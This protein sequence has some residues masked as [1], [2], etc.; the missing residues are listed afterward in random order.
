MQTDLSKLTAAADEWEAMAGKFKKL[1]DQYRK[2]IHGVTVDGSWV[3]LSATAAN[4]HFKVTLRE[5]QA[6]QTEAKAIAALVRDAYSQFVDLRGKVQAA[7]ADAIEAGM[8]VS[9]QGAVFFDTEKLSPSNRSAY[10]HDP[11]YQESGRA[12]AAKWEQAID[13]AVKAVTDADAGVKI[14][15]NAVVVDTDVLDGTMNGFNAKAKSDIEKYEADQMAEIS[16]R[17]NSGTAT[18]QD[19]KEAERSLRDN[20]GNKVY[21][22]TLL[23]SLGPD[24]TIKFTNKLNDLAYFDD[25]DRKKNYLTLQKGLSTSLAVA[26]R[27]PDFGADGK[28]LPPGSKQET[29]AIGSRPY[30]EAVKNWRTTGDAKFYNNWLNGMKE[31]GT[32]EYDTKAV[33]ELTE[34][35]RSDDKAHGYQSLVTMMQQGGDYSGTFLHDLAD[36]IR[37]A[38]DPKQKGNP[39]IWDIGAEYD[40]RNKKNGGGWFANDPMDGVLGLMSKD[41]DTATAYFDPKG[42]QFSDNSGSGDGAVV[43]HGSDRLNYLQNERDWE[44]VGDIVLTHKDQVSLS[45]PDA[46]DADSGIGFG[47]ALEAAATGRPPG[48]ADVPEGYERHSAAQ[49]RVFEEI[50]RSY[51][52]SATSERHGSVIPENMRQNMGNIVA[53][54]PD[55]IHQ[56]LGKN[57]DFSSPEYSTKPNDLNVSN[58]E[59][60]RF[61]REASADGGAYRTIHDSQVGVIAQEIDGLSKG[62]L[63]IRPGAEQ[64][65]TAMGVMRES[66]YV[67]GTLDQIRAD[68]LTDNRDAEISQNNWNK[69]YQY[70]LF[71]APVTGLPF[72]GDGIQR[73][74][75]IGTGKE[76]E[77]LNNAATGR[78]R[79]E[80][81]KYYDENGYPRL[82]R[83]LSRHISE[84]GI[85]PEQV[86]EK[87]SRVSELTGTARGAYGDGLDSADGSTGEQG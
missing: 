36:D 40:G 52:E 47:L 26:T 27:V 53:H 17:I 50:I 31:V 10:Q 46:Q 74:I 76:A 75:D 22:Q 30:A 3:G 63:T 6:A 12:E 45:V 41:P 65:D 14:A 39:D 87:G 69:A 71:G 56:I 66:G 54:Y 78:A 79:E 4:E 82:N 51:A 7:R 34:L 67:M 37:R 25:K 84:V 70:H 15:L 29:L 38:E 11:S 85:P 64:A 32:K 43:Q 18:A 8:K 62:D 61:L 9:A 48:T 77:E 83:M 35:Q 20:S 60:T 5:L 72:F 42:F 55:D 44:V 13:R 80:L 68:V 86:M 16:T 57:A 2:N 73:M 81:I 19:L 1:E 59:L 58:G 21:S 23:N 28:P 33:T 24:G 49:S